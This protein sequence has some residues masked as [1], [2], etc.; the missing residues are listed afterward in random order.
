MKKIIAIFIFT[1]LTG[2]TSASFTRFESDTNP[3]SYPYP[4][5][6][7]QRW[8]FTPW[9]CTEVSKKDHFYD[10]VTDGRIGLKCVSPTR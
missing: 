7:L 2:S 9:A 8:I 10:I 6:A 1:L 5:I 3:V 4:Q